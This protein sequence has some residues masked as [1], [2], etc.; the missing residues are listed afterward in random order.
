MH[1]NDQQNNRSSSTVIEIYL[2]SLTL[3]IV[4]EKLSLYEKAIKT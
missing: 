2:P 1:L 4:N 3:E